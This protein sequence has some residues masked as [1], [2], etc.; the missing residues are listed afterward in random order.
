MSEPNCPYCG[1]EIDTTDFFEFD[2]STETDCPECEKE[3]HVER[4]VE[5]TYKI[6]RLECKEDH[7]DWLE[8]RRHD[9]DEATLERWKDDD[10][11]KSRIH[12][13]VYTFFCRNCS[14]CDEMQFS[15]QFPLGTRL[16]QS[17]IKP[18]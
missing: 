2:D 8:W 4:E 14:L 9:I 6:T 11:F 5:V 3:F 16:E 18:R 17:E 15:K 1:A 7:H 10:F 12:E 13:G